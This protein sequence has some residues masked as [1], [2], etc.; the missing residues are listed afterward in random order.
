M[1]Y[2][3]YSPN[4][5]R[6]RQPER[7]RLWLLWRDLNDRYRVGWLVAAAVVLAAGWHLLSGYRPG[8]PGVMG[9]QAFHSEPASNFYLAASGLEVAQLAEQ[10][11]S[12]SFDAIADIAV[13]GLGDRVTVFI[14]FADAETP[15]LTE[16]QVRAV[17]HV[18]QSYPAL[19]PAVFAALLDAYRQEREMM[20]GGGEE[21]GVVGR[22]IL[23]VLGI[24]SP[25]N[26]MPELKN[27]GEL[28]ARL[29]LPSVYVWKY[30][31]DGLA[32]VA[33]TFQPE[34]TVNP[35]A[36]VIHG[37]KVLK[38]GSHVDMDYDVAVGFSPEDEASGEGG[39]GGP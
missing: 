29:F 24:P 3:E 32:Y 27:E 11:G 5:D 23:W 34:W 9:A 4:P 20:I 12:G 39:E 38:A 25:E 14:G 26:M 37:D 2:E 30:E 10:F 13:D 31:K 36:V 35:F 17:D 21:L 8:G 16:A 22:A 15:K 28:A 6:R 18:R 33:V 7:V 1:A 19:R